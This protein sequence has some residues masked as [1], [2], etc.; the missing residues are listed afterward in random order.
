VGQ[1][2]CFDVG[3]CVKWEELEEGRLEEGRV[4]RGTSIEL[5]T[6]IFFET[7]FLASFLASLYSGSDQ[8][9]PLTSKN[10]AEKGNF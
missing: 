10:R 4:G 7:S 1:R 3:A 6:A 2:K 9:I 8:T 5:L